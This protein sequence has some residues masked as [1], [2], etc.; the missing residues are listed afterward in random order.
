MIRSSSIKDIDIE[1]ELEKEFS[2]NTMGGK[3][4]NI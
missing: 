1:K 2:K 3:V 4:S